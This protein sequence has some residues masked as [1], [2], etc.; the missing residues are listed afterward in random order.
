MG[1]RLC[2]GVPQYAKAAHLEPKCDIGVV[3]IN[4]TLPHAARTPEVLL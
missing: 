3:D 2:Q 1:S 4:G